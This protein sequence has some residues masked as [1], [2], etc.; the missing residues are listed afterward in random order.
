MLLRQRPQASPSSK[1]KVS[2]RAS[3]EQP[4]RLADST[5]SDSLTPLHTQ[6]YTVLASVGMRS[7]AGR[8]GIYINA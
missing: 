4:R 1:P 3:G 6:T 8:S 2:V 5:A 7:P